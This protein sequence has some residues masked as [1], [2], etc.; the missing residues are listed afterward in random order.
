MTSLLVETVDICIKRSL[1]NTPKI[2]GV[3][4]LRK[5]NQR[6]HEKKKIKRSQINWVFK[7]KIMGKK[8]LNRNCWEFTQTLA[9]E[10]EG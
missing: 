9:S 3:K 8:F 7:Q 10:I 6:H 1:Q 5:M 2:Q 4:V